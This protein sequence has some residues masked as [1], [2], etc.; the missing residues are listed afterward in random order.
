MNDLEHG[1]S[2]CGMHTIIGTPTTVYREILKKKNLKNKENISH[3]RFLTSKISD[4][5]I[6]GT[7]L[8]ASVLKLMLSISIKIRVIHKIC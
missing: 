8:S 6:Q 5:I 2:N 1:F 4:N 3:V 7:S